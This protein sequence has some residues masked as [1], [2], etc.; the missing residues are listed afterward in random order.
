MGRQGFIPQ[1]CGVT[2]LNPHDIRHNMALTDV[3]PKW[4][5][6]HRTLCRLRIPLRDTAS[7]PLPRTDGASVSTCLHELHRNV[8]GATPPAARAVVTVTSH[9]FDRAGQ[10]RYWLRHE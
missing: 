10:S 5:E 6:R 4:G 8:G 7:P 3:A 9:G 2:E 1:A